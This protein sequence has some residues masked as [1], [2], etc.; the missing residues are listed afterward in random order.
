MKALKAYLLNE[1][2]QGLAISVHVFSNNATGFVIKIIPGKDI[3][4]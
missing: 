4:I 2:R 3:K 1:A